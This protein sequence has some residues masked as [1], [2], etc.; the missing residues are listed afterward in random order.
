[1]MAQEDIT[2][3]KRLRLNLT[4][5]QRE[6]LERMRDRHP[7]PYLRE[8]AAALLQIA[9]GRSGR[10]VALHGLLKSRDP[11]TVYAWVRRYKEEGLE[12]LKIK[13]GRGRKAAFSP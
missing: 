3:P 5:E 8:R 1:M 9:D 11:D 10:G 12:G 2:M 13:P 7:K 6:E 4:S